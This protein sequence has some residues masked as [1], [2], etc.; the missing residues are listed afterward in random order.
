MPMFIVVASVATAVTQ[1][2]IRDGLEYICV[3]T[4]CIN[5][6]SSAELSEAIN[7]MM[8]WYEHAVVCYTHSA[9]IP[10]DLD[11]AQLREFTD[12][13]MAAVRSTAP[14]IHEWL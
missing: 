3:D 11:E 2:A 4:Y 8:S 12:A 6:T 10:S 5:K 1:Q 7:S 14:W 9:D 13:G